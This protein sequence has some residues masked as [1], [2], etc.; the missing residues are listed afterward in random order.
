MT[1]AGA[2]AGVYGELATLQNDTVKVYD[3]EP[4]QGWNRPLAITVSLGPLS[5]TDYGVTVRVY[6]ST[7][8]DVKDAQTSLTTLVELVDGSLDEVTPRTTWQ[9]VWM[10]DESA[11][12]T[13][14]VLLVPREDF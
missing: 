13:S 9:T 2:I 4:S 1:W 3:H 5:V 6:S 10:P 11:W 12:C 8:T 14:T 7:A